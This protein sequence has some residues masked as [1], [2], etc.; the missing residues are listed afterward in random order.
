MHFPFIWNS[1]REMRASQHGYISGLGSLSLDLIQVRLLASTQLHPIM[2]LM[3]DG[4]SVFQ[5]LKLV[6]LLDC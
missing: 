5:V 6:R 1:Q 4:H 2:W 3:G